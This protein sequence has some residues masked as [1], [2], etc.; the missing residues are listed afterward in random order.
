MNVGARICLIDD[1]IYVRDA[2]TFGLRDAG[3]RVVTAPG[4][5]AGLDLIRREGADV[6]I[7]DMNMPGT[8]GAEL[9]AQARATWPSMVIIAISGD[10]VVNGRNVAD[11]ASEHGANAALIKPFRLPELTALIDRL[12][13]H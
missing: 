2:L 12:L 5:A 4:A 3:Y 1:D 10:G 9:I 11:L 6:I 7:T 13:E 8:D